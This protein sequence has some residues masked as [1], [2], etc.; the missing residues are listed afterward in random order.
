MKSEKNP[1]FFSILVK[2]DKISKLCSEIR[3]HGQHVVFDDKKQSFKYS[4]VL[5]LHSLRLVPNYFELSYKNAN[6]KMKAISQFNWGYSILL[7]SI[8]TVDDYLEVQ[9][10]SKYRSIIRRYVRRLEKCFDIEYKLFH[11]TINVEDYDFLMKSLH[12][13]MVKR[14]QQRKEEHK[15]M[16][17]WEKIVKTTYKL[18]LDGN[19][20]LFVIYNG[21]QPIEISL[22]YHFDKILFSTISSY[23]IDYSKFGLGHVE[24]YKQLEWC[25][26]NGYI[27]FEMGVGGM[28]YKRR[29]SNNIYNYEHRIVY[30]NIKGGNLLAM[31]EIN[32]IKLK[33]YLKSKKLNTL[34]DRFF[35]ILKKN[36]TTSITPDFEISKIENFENNH[37][38]EDLEQIDLRTTNFSFLKKYVNDFLYATETHTSQVKVYKVI[39]NDTF[40]INGKGK[41]QKITGLSSF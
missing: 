26:K 15:N 6:Y 8:K 25:L 18:I 38:V 13:M 21:K 41:I 9:F 2:T 28:D 34:R 3:Y 1:E 27:L 32:K 29:W 24:I 19:A 10:K 22:N 12:D 39:Q 40:Y 4:P 5:S 35:G 31:V 20:S 11:R 23:D 17:E 37:Q 7:N 33:E 16:D 36:D 14:F 30:Q